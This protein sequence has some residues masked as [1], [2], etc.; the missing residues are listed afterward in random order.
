MPETSPNPGAR[1]DVISLPKLLKKEIRLD[2]P[3]LVKEI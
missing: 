1:I 2:H 3:S